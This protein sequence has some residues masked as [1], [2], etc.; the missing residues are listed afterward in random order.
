MSNWFYLKL[1]FSDPEPTFQ[2]ISVPD[3][4]P[5]PAPDPITDPLTDPT[6]ISMEEAKEKFLKNFGRTNFFTIWKKSFHSLHV[7]CFDFVK[8]H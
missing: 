4:A 2:I 5:D 3:P 8:I 1:F 6:K 7:K